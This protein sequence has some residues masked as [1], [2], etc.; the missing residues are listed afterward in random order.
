MA[1]VKV[2]PLMLS[3]SVV[4]LSAQHAHSAAAMVSQP[5]V[6]IVQG[7]R[8]DSPASVPKPTAVQKPVGVSAEVVSEVVYPSATR[9]PPQQATELPSLPKGDFNVTSED[10]LDSTRSARV[11]SLSVGG[12]SGFDNHR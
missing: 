12:G 2:L 10:I 9:S 8:Q 3:I 5:I 1:Q 4:L 7:A 11:I 6:P